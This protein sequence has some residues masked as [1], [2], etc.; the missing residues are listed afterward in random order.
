MIRRTALLTVAAAATAFTAAAPAVAAPPR[1]Y[2]QAMKEITASKGYQAGAEGTFRTPTG[3]IFCSIGIENP[4][5]GLEACELRTST[6]RAT[7]AQC[8]PQ[9][10]RRTIGRIEVVRR[11]YRAVCNT[12]TIWQRGAPVLRYGYVSRVRGTPTRCLSTTAGVVCVNTKLRRG[13]FLSRS[14]YRIF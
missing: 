4:D 2:A 11:G 14:A 6:I 13:F 12:D 10:G 5:L 9:I 3:N 8:S 1:T 7:R